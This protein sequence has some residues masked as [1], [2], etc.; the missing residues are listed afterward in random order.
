MADTI[1]LEATAR[2]RAGKG[3]ARAVR[4]E[5]R[6]PAV[7]Y[8][9]KKDP[10]LIS[11]D[12]RDTWKHVQ[13][14]RFLATLVDVNVGGEKIRAIP[15]D[16][17]FD[18][19][20]DFVVHIDFLRLGKG[21]RIA[22][23]VPCNFTNEEESPGIRRGGVLNVVRHE[24][25]VYCPAESI[26]EQ[27]DIDLTGLDIGDGVHISAVTLPAG[28]EPTISD[29]DFTICTIAAPAGLASEDGA[30]ADEDEVEAGD[31]PTVGEAAAEE[32]ASED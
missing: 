12:Y 19:V 31:V 7:I 13:N 9:D 17:Q 1:T 8:G 10:Q 27:F 21:A 30:D 11:L 22:V 24:I 6:V 23:N 2:E 16:I 3:A 26:P 28:V 25:E 5:G 14:G 32:E 20:K 29:R 4:R 15:R 18:P